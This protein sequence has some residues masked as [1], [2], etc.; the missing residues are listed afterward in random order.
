M[1]RSLRSIVWLENTTRNWSMN[2]QLNK[3]EGREKR[4]DREREREREKFRPSSRVTDSGNVSSINVLTFHEKVGA[5]L[6]IE[7]TDFLVSI[8]YQM[9]RNRGLCTHRHQFRT[10]VIGDNRI[11]ISVEL[12]RIRTMIDRLSWRGRDEILIKIS[13]PFECYSNW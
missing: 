12:N 10:T 1:C 6:E 7:T 3:K 11:A 5:R 9:T 8:P 13:I 4:R 2:D